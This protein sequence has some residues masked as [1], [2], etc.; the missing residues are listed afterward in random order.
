M[1]AKIS[2][3]TETAMKTKIAEYARQ[4]NMTLTG[5]LNYIV[6]CHFDRIDQS[7]DTLKRLEDKIDTLLLQDNRQTKNNNNKDNYQ[8]IVKCIKD[9]SQD[10][11]AVAL[12]ELID[13]IPELK[14]IMD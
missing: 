10:I 8:K 13:I 12:I 6:N 5:V 2:F 9:N 11:C 7:A 14:S 1:K 4:Q 3:D